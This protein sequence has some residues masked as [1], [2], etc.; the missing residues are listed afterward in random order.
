[1]VWEI[2]KPVDKE[3]VVKTC[4]ALFP[5]IIGDY[6]VWLQRYYKTWD[7]LYAG[8]WSDYTPRYFITKQE[9][10]YHVKFKQELKVK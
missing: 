9:A 6:K 5:K 3:L 7:W 4:F 10:E 8:I 2:K 1:M